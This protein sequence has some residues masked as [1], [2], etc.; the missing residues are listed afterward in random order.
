MSVEF[1]AVTVPQRVSRRRFVLTQSGI[2][3]ACESGHVQVFEI[4]LQ[5]QTVLLVRLGNRKSPWEHP[6]NGPVTADRDADQFLLTPTA[7]LPQW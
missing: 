7:P 1:V 2:T 5:S 6:E 3:G 4:D